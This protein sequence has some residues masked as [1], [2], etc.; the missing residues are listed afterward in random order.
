M[1]PAWLALAL[2]LAALLTSCGNPPQSSGEAGRL[3]NSMK[4]ALRAQN[5]EGGAFSQVVALRCRA[6]GA[7][8]RYDCGASV[9]ARAFVFR[10]SYRVQLGP[11]GCWTAYRVALGV[12]RGSGLDAEGPPPGGLRGCIR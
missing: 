3:E 8:R 2:C 12:L 9:R 10:D 1:R 11:D 5:R 4:V 6:A 7:P